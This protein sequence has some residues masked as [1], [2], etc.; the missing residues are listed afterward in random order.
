MWIMCQ[1]CTLRLQFN[2]ACTARL[3]RVRYLSDYSEDR[4][5]RGFQN[6]I[7]FSFCSSSNDFG[8]HCL[9]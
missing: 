8:F 6:T 3:P 2:V 7:P 4:T 5:S 9:L 1:F